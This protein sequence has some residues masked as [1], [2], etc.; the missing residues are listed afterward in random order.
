[1]K[2]Y[3][4]FKQYKNSTPEHKTNGTTTEVSPWNNKLFPYFANLDITFTILCLKKYIVD[5]K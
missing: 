1:M 4:G 3:I 2:T 5:D